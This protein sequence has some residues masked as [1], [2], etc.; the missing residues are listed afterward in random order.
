MEWHRI[1]KPFARSCHGQ[2]YRCLREYGQEIVGQGQ[3]AFCSVGRLDG[4]WKNG[5][6][7]CFFCERTLDSIGM[8]PSHLLVG[9]PCE[10]SFATV[11]GSGERMGYIYI[12]IC[13]YKL[14]LYIYI[15]IIYFIYIVTWLVL[16]ETSKHLP[17]WM[18][19]PLES[20]NKLCWRW[21]IYGDVI[22]G[23]NDHPKFIDLGWWR[24]RMRI[25]YIYLR[26]KLLTQYLFAP[27]GMYWNLAIYYK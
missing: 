20:P 4:L 21:G 24:T 2:Q 9:D 3:P 26:A 22:G 25:Y 13:R 27:T 19:M 15:Y 10:F 16:N 18:P 17:K 23:I 12:Y 1:W 14:Y 11:T 6:S 7:S 5:E 8:L